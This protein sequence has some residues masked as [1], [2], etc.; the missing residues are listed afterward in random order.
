VLTRIEEAKKRGIFSMRSGSVHNPDDSWIVNAEKEHNNSNFHGIISQC[1]VTKP[2][3]LHCER[4]D[5]SHPRWKVEQGALLS[6]DAGTFASALRLLLVNSNAIVFIDPYFNPGEPDMVQPLVAFSTLIRGKSVPIEIHS[7]RRVSQNTAQIRSMAE[8][9]LCPVLPK[10]QVVKIYIRSE[11]RDGDRIHNRYLLT[12]IGGVQFGDS[13]A[14]GKGQKDRVSILEEP[15][16]H[17][18]WR[19]YVN[20]GRD[21]DQN[22]THVQIIGKAR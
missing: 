2:H 13:I 3:F 5:E 15:S 18:L 7:S 4:V 14:S 17:T 6:R 1:E 19:Q 12:D 22:G 11:K 21:F 20:P 8:S 10:G 16:R 9:R